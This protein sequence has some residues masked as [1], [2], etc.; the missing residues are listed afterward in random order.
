MSLGDGDAAKISLIS[1]DNKKQRGF[2]KDQNPDFI[3][4][5][6]NRVFIIDAN[7]LM[8]SYNISMPI[9]VEE[10]V[11]SQDQ[12]NYLTTGKYCTIHTSC[13]LNNN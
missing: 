3:F 7:D 9:K 1:K 5:L 11:W 2:Q 6:N 13:I 10:H 4:T 8:I 12:Q